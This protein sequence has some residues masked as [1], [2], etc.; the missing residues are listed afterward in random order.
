MFSPFFAI[1]PTNQPPN[2]HGW[3]YNLLLTPYSCWIKWASEKI[4][5]SHQNICNT[6]LKWTFACKVEL[7][8]YLLS[9][10][11]HTHLP[12]ELYIQS[13]WINNSSVQPAERHPTPRLDFCPKVSYY[14]KA[15]LWHHWNGYCS[16]P[17]MY[18][19]PAATHN[20]FPSISASCSAF[21]IDR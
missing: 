16:E 6:S 3:I 19:V 13:N 4:F 9:C 21:S 11:Q 18:T 12:L 1:L 7:H 15:S 14:P 5:V 10:S 20:S 2:K 17:E 8:P